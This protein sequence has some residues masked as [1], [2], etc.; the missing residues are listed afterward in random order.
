MEYL[1][2]V[3]WGRGER[4]VTSRVPRSRE[5]LSEKEAGARGFLRHTERKILMSNQPENEN[6]SQMDASQ[7]GFIE[8]SDEQLEHVAG[9]A[10]VFKRIFGRIRGGSSSGEGSGSS[11]GY[12]KD[13]GKAAATGVIGTGAGYAFESGLNQT[14][15]PAT[16]VHEPHPMP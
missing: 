9:G 5:L 16:P 7:Q 3:L 1:Y 8:L 6:L 11:G 13:G 4:S 10:N 15:G 2:Q 14:L 12:L